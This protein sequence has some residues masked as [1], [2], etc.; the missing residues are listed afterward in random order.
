MNY[1]APTLP[2]YLYLKRN[3]EISS[4]KGFRSIGMRGVSGNGKVG[5]NEDKSRE[6]GKVRWWS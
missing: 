1:S 3:Q 2:L 6:S 5:K 4:I